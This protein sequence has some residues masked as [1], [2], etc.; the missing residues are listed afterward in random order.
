MAKIHH[1]VPVCR[2][3]LS[4]FNAFFSGQINQTQSLFTYAQ[5]E[6]VETFAKSDFTPMFVEDITWYNNSVRELAEAQ[7]GNDIECL[8]DAAATNDVSIGIVT[9]DINIQLVNES[10]TLGKLL[11]M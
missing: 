6:S 4:L 10:N 8:F 9:K 5:N 11:K 7:C 2:R 3:V 1:H